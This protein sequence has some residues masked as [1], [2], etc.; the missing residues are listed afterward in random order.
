M[1]SDHGGTSHEP[2]RAE[3]PDEDEPPFGAESEPVDD[4]DEE[5]PDEEDDE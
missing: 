4:A 5:V 3:E 1:N 2:W